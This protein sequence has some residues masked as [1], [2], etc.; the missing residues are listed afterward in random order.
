MYMNIN[1]RNILIISIIFLTIYLVINRCE[2]FE[3]NLI[4][5]EKL[6]SIFKNKNLT[7]RNKLRMSHEWCANM[8]NSKSISTACIPMKYD[9]KQYYF[10]IS[11]CCASD[12]CRLLEDENNVFT[13][14]KNNNDYY[15]QKNGEIVQLVE[16]YDDSKKCI[17]E[18]REKEEIYYPLISLDKIKRT[19]CE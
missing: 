7:K 19:V 14:L 13:I 2:F 5:D 17:E 4:Y 6:T 16:K 1:L 9:N 11:V 8:R 10:P 12:Y 18:T 3:D 15:L